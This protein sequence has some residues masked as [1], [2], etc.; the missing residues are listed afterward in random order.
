M[1]A[2]DT[3]SPLTCPGPETQ[4]LVSSE[5]S[6]WEEHPQPVGGGEDG[7]QKCL[8]GDYGTSPHACAHGPSTRSRSAAKRQH[9]QLVLQTGKFFF[10]AFKDL[11]LHFTNIKTKFS[12]WPWT[13]SKRPALAEGHDLHTPPGDIC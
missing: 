11:Q 12:S 6:V 4:V 13:A 2:A 1:H 9:L 3:A 7:G 5:P 10:S 8:Q